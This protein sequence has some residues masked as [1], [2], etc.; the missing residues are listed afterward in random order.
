METNGGNNNIITHDFPVWREK[1]N[2]I[3]AVRLHDDVPNAVDWEQI[4]STQVEEN[5][6]E[7]CCIPFFAYNIALGDL[8]TT[9]RQGS[10]KYAIEKVV[11]QSGHKTYRIWFLNMDNWGIAVHAIRKLGCLV[12]KRW[13]R[14]KLISVDAPTFAV[15]EQLEAYLKKQEDNQELNYEVGLK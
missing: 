2:F 8:V 13:E 15:A 4:W 14:S 10:R 7:V 11:E 12:E 1:A 5:V 9:S 3:I 6:F